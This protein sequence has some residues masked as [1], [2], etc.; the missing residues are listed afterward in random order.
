MPGIQPANP[1]RGMLEKPLYVEK[2][3]LQLPETLWVHPL[4]IDAATYGDPGTTLSAE[5]CDASIRRLRHMPSV[6]DHAGER[7]MRHTMPVYTWAIQLLKQR[8]QK[9]GSGSVLSIIERINRTCDLIHRSPSPEST[10]RYIQSLEV[11]VPDTYHAYLPNATQDFP[12]II[13]AM[14][15]I[16]ILLLDNYMVHRAD[17]KQP[18]L[19]RIYKAVESSLDYNFTTD[20]IRLEPVLNWVC[21]CI[22]VKDQPVTY[23]DVGCAV[24]AGAPG[25]VKAREMFDEKELNVRMHG[26][27]IT[28]PSNELATALRETHRIALYQSDVVQRKLPSEY[29][30]ILL[31][32]VHR[33]LSQSEQNAML[34]NLGV[35]LKQRGLLFI[36]WRFDQHSSP[37]VCLERVNEELVIKGEKNCV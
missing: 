28:I 5:R 6:S 1:P 26:T 9:N 36:N 17:L 2:N 25:L 32:N 20:T 27:D 22:S 8:A 14:K 31:A 15:V 24:Q 23:V 21:E 12:D 3:R 7:V 13:A 10:A 29:D 34:H 4:F 33:H 19:K 35:S 11:V 16:S 37:C 18:Y 30:C